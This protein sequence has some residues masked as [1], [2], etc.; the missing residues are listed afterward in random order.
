MR[1]AKQR[2]REPNEMPSTCSIPWPRAS[3]QEGWERNRPRP[4]M[5]QSP[6]EP[7]PGGFQERKDVQ[8]RAWDVK[9]E[10]LL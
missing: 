5:D 8:E 9:F 2:K 6:P 3:A 1:A 10:D 7:V 4:G